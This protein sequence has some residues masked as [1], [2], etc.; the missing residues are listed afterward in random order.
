MRYQ[1]QVLLAARSRKTGP[2]PIIHKW[3]VA[4]P[5]MTLGFTNA[6]SLLPPRFVTN[7]QWNE[8]RTLAPMAFANGW[9][10]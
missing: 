3:Q 6:F 10:V 7:A 5:R 2:S 9:G 8:R 1:R 4:F